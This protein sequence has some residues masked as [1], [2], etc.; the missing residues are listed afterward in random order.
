MLESTDRIESITDATFATQVEQSSEPFLLEFATAW[1][2]PCAALVPVLEGLA[3]E[4]AGKV[5][6]G[7]I[8]IAEQRTTA[9]HFAVQSTPTMIL[10]VEGRPVL[11]L[12][13]AKNRRNLLEALRDHLA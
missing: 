9:E 7:Q 10:F 8:D 4:L 11:R 3:L 12:M 13:G 2:A 1:C 5:R 6:I